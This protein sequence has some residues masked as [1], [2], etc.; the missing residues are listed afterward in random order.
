M[1]KQIALS[2]TTRGIESR[3]V[4]HYGVKSGINRQVA[5]QEVAR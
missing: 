3:T 5:Q 4:A 1:G 2:V